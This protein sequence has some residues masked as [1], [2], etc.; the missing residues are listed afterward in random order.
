MCNDRACFVPFAYWL[1][2]APLAMAV[3]GGEGEGQQV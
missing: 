3:N 1:V 2:A